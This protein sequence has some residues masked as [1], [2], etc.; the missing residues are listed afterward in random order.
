MSIIE[1]VVQVLRDPASS[2]ALTG[3]GIAV[4]I[5]MSKRA[6]QE[7]P[8]PKKL[9]QPGRSSRKRHHKNNKKRVGR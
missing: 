3:I 1:T 8:T 4:S 7:P 9:S 2:T 5:W 6:G